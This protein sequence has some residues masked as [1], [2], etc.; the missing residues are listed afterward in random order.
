MQ[1]YLTDIELEFFLTIQKYIKS[2][3]SSK[4]VKKKDIRNA[5]PPSRSAVK[6][7]INY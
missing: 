7:L 1:I 3:P 2:V 4:K 6:I 5:K